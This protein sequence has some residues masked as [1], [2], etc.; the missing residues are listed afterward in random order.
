[1]AEKQLMVVVGAK[2][3]EFEKAMGDMQKTLSTAGRSMT[4]VGKSMTLLTAPLAGLGALSIST[5]A[6]FDDSM[7]QVK[8]ISG[9]V[10][11]EFDSLRRLAQD[12]G[13]TTAHSASDAADAMSYLAL[14]GW[15]TNQIL[16][17]TPD[18]LS[19]ASA[20]ALDLARTADIVTD[21]MSAFGMEAKDAGKA[22]D[23]FAAASSESN[24]NVALLGE[25]MKHAG[26]QANASKMDLEETA[27]VI[28]ILS[29][30]GVKGSMAGTSINAMLRDLKSASAE[31]KLEFDG[32]NVS[33]Y[34]TDGSM[35]KF[36]DVIQDVSDA[37]KHLTDEQR[38]QALGAVFQAQSL[39]GVNVLLEAGTERYQEL[40]SE[41]RNSEGAAKQ[42]ADTMEDNIAGA[43]RALKSQTEG[44]LIQLGDLLVPIIMDNVIPALQSMGDKISAALTWF[45]E[46]DPWVQNLGIALAGLFVAVGPVLIILGQLVTAISNL[47]PVVA[48]I[49]VALTGLATGPVAPFVLIG[50]AIAGLVIIWQ[51]FGDDIIEFVKNMVEKVVGFLEPFKDT[52]VAIFTWIHDHTIGIFTKMWDGIK[53]IINYI[54][55]GVN[56]MIVSLNRIS[57]DIPDW[58]P[59]M[60]GT[61]F[62]FNLKTIPMLADGGLIKGSG[63][64]IVGERGPELLHLPR[65]AAVEPLPR[66]SSGQP[67]NLTNNFYTHRE[68]DER[69]VERKTELTIRRLELEYGR[70]F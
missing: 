9:A 54:I 20:G 70:R 6:K 8:A 30:A 43:F 48:A 25:A 16:E 13:A 21:T 32:L 7:S 68:L 37:T 38:D 14:A 2:T 52:F 22:A 69:E 59:G 51:K 29:D 3:E 58:V 39:R 4:D 18:M 33:L 34:E 35:R 27:T 12:L 31:G 53:R 55:S 61:K 24:T 44:I 17:A 47:M 11:E 66:N 42:M 49:K 64:A 1:M 65:G 56:K 26:A 60:G 45:S 28:G 67:I 46:L 57:I 40:E 63:F 5:V 62:G 36:G 10:G 19:L 41:I 50:A 23:I 15:D